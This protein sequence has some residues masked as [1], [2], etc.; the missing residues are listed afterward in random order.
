MAA[1]AIELHNQLGQ[2]C[3]LTLAARPKTTWRYRRVDYHWVVTINLSTAHHHFAYNAG[4]MRAHF[5]DMTACLDYLTPAIL[6]DA[7][8]EFLAQ[9]LAAEALTEPTALY[10]DIGVIIVPAP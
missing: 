8:G 3:L 2:S 5:A 7:F 10:R 9:D 6:S 4:F 1:K